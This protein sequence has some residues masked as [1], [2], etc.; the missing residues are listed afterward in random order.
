MKKLILVSL[1][2]LAALVR[3][4]AQTVVGQT[5]LTFVLGILADNNGTP[6]ADG[7]LLQIL[8]SYH[9][10]S[11]SAATPTDFLGGDTGETVIWQGAVDSTTADNTPG[12]SILNFNVNLYADGTPGNYLTAGSTLFVRWYPTLSAASVSPGTTLYGQYG[13]SAADGTVLDST[14]VLQSIGT[15]PQYLFVT[16]GGGGTIA[17]T[18]GQATLSTAVPEPATTAALLGG[19]G[20]IF[21][22]FIRR[23]RS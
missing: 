5:N 23:K 4:P 21:G 20:L 2:S 22:W 18:A 12:A 11:L 17:D 7:G 1:L 14:W 6:V 16:V 9:G 13:Y 3:L 15:N 10:T 8:A 19:V